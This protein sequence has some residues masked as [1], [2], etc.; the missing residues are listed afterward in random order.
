MSLPKKRDG[1]TPGFRETC[2]NC[3]KWIPGN[4]S[5]CPKCR[6]LPYPRVCDFH[7]AEDRIFRAKAEMFA[8]QHHL[9]VLNNMIRK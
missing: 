4:T 3:G 2:L 8:A 5:Y 1:N 9:E 7:W 6:K